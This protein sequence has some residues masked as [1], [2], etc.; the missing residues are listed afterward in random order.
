MKLSDTTLLFCGVLWL[1]EVGSRVPG[2]RWGSGSSETARGL[3]MGRGVQDMWH[4][5]IYIDR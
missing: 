5:G 4:V 1:L 3:R 2:N